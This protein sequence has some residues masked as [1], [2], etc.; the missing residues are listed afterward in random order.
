MEPPARLRAIPDM[1]TTD[2]DAIARS[3]SEHY[4]S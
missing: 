2:A 1:T 3:L 4:V